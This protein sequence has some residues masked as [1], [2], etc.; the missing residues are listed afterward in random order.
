MKRAEISLVLVLALAGSTACSREEQADLDRTV[1]RAENGIQQTA[2]QWTND[3]REALNDLGNEFDELETRN[4]NL[5]GESAAAWTE[6]R[7]Q[8]RQIRQ[9]LAN[10]VDRLQTSTAEEAHEVR[11][12]IARNFEGMTHRVER[13]KLLATD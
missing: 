12:R 3:A 5:Q 6:V 1:E 11:A 10:D 4:A 13:A 2:D 8:V 9:E 7:D